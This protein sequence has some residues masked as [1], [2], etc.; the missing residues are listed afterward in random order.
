MDRM[1]AIAYNSCM[2]GIVQLKQKIAIFIV[3]KHEL[4]F[5]CVLNTLTEL[6]L[7]VV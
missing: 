1:A 3:F 2:Q 5:F 7:N 4:L 6:L